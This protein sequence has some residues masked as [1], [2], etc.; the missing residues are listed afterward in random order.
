MAEFQTLTTR[1]VAE[2]VYDILRD[3]ILSCELAPGQ[4]LD[5]AQI[6]I[7]LSVSRTPVKDALQ[8]LSVQDLVEIHPRRGTFVSKITPEDVRETFEVREA[9][10]VKACDLAAGKLKPETI[11]KLR[12]LN[13]RMFAPDLRFGDHV[14]L[15][16]ELHRT[17][18]ESAGN[19][20]LLKMYSEL[21]AH[22]QIARVHYRSTNWRTHNKTT[23]SEH[24]G[25]IDALAAGRGEDARRAMQTHIRNSM[26]RLIS[27]I[28]HPSVDSA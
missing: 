21:K 14:V 15:D 11:E 5:V 28:L 13:Q 7:Q 16:S 3:K 20:R 27:G 8:R 12:D 4:R 1:G 9:L 19:Q 6:S 22:V 26:N 25:V 24:L 10:E 17:I 23:S 2:E 18:I